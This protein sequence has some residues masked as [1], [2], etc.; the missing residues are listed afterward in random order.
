MILGKN[1]K[2]YWIWGCI[3]TLFLLGVFF[4]SRGKEKNEILLLTNGIKN[5]DDDD[6]FKGV[7]E[8][9]EQNGYVCKIQDFQPGEWVAGK[10]V[11]MLRKMVS[12]KTAGIVINAAVDSNNLNNLLK[13]YREKGIKIISYDS[14]VENESRDL[15]VGAVEPYATGR[16][17]LKEAADMSD[18]KGKVVII[19]ES[20]WSESITTMIQGIRYALETHRYPDMVFSDVLFYKDSTDEV[21]QS[22]EDYFNE[23]GEDHIFLCLSE[24]MTEAAC[25]AAK[26]CALEEKIKIVGIG[27]TQNLKED[28]V[29]EKMQLS[30]FSYDLEDFGEKLAQVALEVV[31]G[32]I[33]GGYGETVQLSSHIY[34]IGRYGNY[35]DNAE[36]RKR[37]ALYFYSMYETEHVG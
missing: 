10:Q 12:E 5:T 35:Q 29:S 9:I 2:R 22:L 20:A 7:E 19:S 33:K 13:E 31:A 16:N 21:A 26:N 17:F 4:Y 3:L 23:K 8:I 1:K 18:A 36:K 11:Q 34:K 14:D 27:K 6:M 32:Q 28:I 24:R 25:M 37:N 30:L 15:H